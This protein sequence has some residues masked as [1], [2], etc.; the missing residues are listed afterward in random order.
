[1][2]NHCE[3]QLYVSGPKPEIDHLKEFFRDAFAKRDKAILT[4]FMPM[5]EVLE[6]TRSPD[7]NP[8]LAKAMRQN[9]DLMDISAEELEA[10]I[11]EHEASVQKN[12]RAKEV[13][14]YSNWYDWCNQHW[15]TKW[16]DYDAFNFEE[17]DFEF[18]YGYHTAWGPF[19]ET[20]MAHISSMH[21]KLY[22]TFAYL[23]PGT[24]FMGVETWNDGMQ[25]YE[26]MSDTQNEYDPSNEE[27]YEL[28]DEAVRGEF[29]H[30]IDHAKSYHPYPQEGWRV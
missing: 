21:P 29:E 26:E 10:R 23:E 11:K 18:A 5:P 4:S 24:D 27:E 30:L 9:S 6:G 12:Q 16:G 8:Q 13:T 2:P 28:W 3:N 14:G 1:M 7:P 20:F 22:F 19:G 25:V 15:G 17:D